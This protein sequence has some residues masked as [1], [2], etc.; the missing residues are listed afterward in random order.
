MCQNHKPRFSPKTQQDTFHTVNE[1][2]GKPGIQVLTSVP[3]LLACLFSL[4]ESFTNFTIIISHSGSRWWQVFCWNCR[5]ECMYNIQNIGL[6]EIIAEINLCSSLPL[7]FFLN[8]NMLHR[9]GV[10]CLS[11]RWHRKIWPWYFCKGHSYFFAPINLSVCLHM[12]SVPPSFCSVKL[13]DFNFENGHWATFSC[14]CKAE[15]SFKDTLTPAQTGNFHFLSPSWVFFFLMR[16][17]FLCNGKDYLTVR[18][19]PLK[20]HT[21][22]NTKKVHIHVCK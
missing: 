8:M 21:H 14:A 19:Y 9:F 3:A 16:F 20:P 17:L 10:T 7:F 1:K 11:R 2:K 12:S 15:R 5:K 18:F 13:N 4:R 22:T 6:G